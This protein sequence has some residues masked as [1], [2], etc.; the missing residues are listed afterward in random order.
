MRLGRDFFY[1]PAAMRHPLSEGEAY[2]TLAWRGASAPR[3]L[4]S[5]EFVY[6]PLQHLV[7]G[8]IDGIEPC[9]VEEVA[10]D[11]GLQQDVGLTTRHELLLLGAFDALLPCPFHQLVEHGI[12]HLEALVEG[13][14]SLVALQL[15]TMLVGVFESIL[16]EQALVDDA[17]EIVLGAVVSLLVW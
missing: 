2:R 16:I 9:V 15:N 7:H 13:L 8:R 11:V 1:S 10:G 17:V 6:C 12:R 4:V 5:L 14:H 3:G